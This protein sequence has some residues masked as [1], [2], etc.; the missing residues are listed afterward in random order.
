MQN[1][2][3]EELGNMK[4]SVI[5]PTLNE[6]NAIG[7]VLND[8]PMDYVHEIIVVDSSTDRTAKMAESLGAKVVFEGRRGYGRALQSGVEKSTGDVIVYIDGDYSYDPREILGIL[9]PILH[10]EC[11]V[12]LGNRLNGRMHPGSMTLLNRLGNTLISLIFSF[13]FLRKVN[14]TQCG[15]RAVRKRFLES[16][17]YKDYEMA[18]VT[19]QLIK[20]IR[21]G[22]RISDVPVTYRPRIGVTKLSMWIDGPKILKVI[23]KGWLNHEE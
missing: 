2:E 20:L 19:E 16:F 7:K 5:I 22:V 10:D 18:Y 4:V 21:K 11:D 6:E 14:D 12:V 17:S 1:Q 3:S 15:F 8:M 13:A 9:R 23:L